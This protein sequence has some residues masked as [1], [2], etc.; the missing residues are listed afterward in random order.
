MEYNKIFRYVFM[1]LLIWV[2]V[3]YITYGQLERIQIATIILFIMACFIFLELYF[4]II[5]Y[6]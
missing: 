1:L 5:C 3:T 6:Q 4:P 2:G